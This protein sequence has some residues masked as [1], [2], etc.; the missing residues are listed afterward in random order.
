M[1]FSRANHHQR[2]TMLSSGKYPPAI[3]STLR[4]LNAHFVPM[5]IPVASYGNLADSLDRYGDVMPV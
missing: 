2:M 3:G 5:I 1:E 4:L